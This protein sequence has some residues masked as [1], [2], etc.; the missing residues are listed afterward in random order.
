MMEVWRNGGEGKVF[1]GSF[2][3]IALIWLCIF[4]FFFVN[5]NNI[6][7]DGREVLLCF[8]IISFSLSHPIFKVGY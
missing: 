3:S 2:A 7:I 6:G 8:F 5:M 1:L 4:P